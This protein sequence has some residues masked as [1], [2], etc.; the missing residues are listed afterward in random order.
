MASQAGGQDPVLDGAGP[1]Y[2]GLGSRA[3]AWGAFTVSAAVHVFFIAIYPRLFGTFEPSS[4]T[5]AAPYFI[6]PS[7][8][9]MEV[10]N[11]VEI[12][13]PPEV[14]RPGEPEMDAVDRR[15]ASVS[16]PA[17]NDV[18]VVDFARPGLTAAERL[19]P[20]VRDRRL[21]APLP[22]EYTQL[23]LEQREELALA[24][25]LAEWYDSV[26]AA[27]A[28]EA[29]MTDWTF[30]DGDGKRWGVADGKL[31]LGGFALP[32]PT[33]GA[34]PGA[35]RERAWEWGELARQG[36]AMA[37]QG[38]IKERMEAIR[39]RRDRERAQEQGDTASVR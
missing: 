24:G 17:L 6:S 18:P 35:A 8:E 20:N 37:I 25:R 38:T 22:E 26:Q 30:T 27:Q 3:I 5:F 13:V 7:S 29:A 19:R 34:A 23:T 39:A 28:A 36:N 11:V 10:L 14:D 32:M 9:A 21:W 33:F 15:E 2:R 31:Y 4:G 16:P 1:P 12:D